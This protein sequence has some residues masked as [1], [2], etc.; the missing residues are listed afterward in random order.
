MTN[1]IHEKANS[2]VKMIL[3]SEEEKVDSTE[4]KTITSSRRKYIHRC[5]A[6]QNLIQ[7]HEFIR[8]VRA[9]RIYHADCF[10][11]SKCKRTLQDDDI[12]SL[13]PADGSPLNDADYLCQRC[14]NPGSQLKKPTAGMTNADE[15]E[16]INFSDF[17]FEKIFLLRL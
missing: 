13:M 2:I 11:C 12:A 15:G 16:T 4:R 3:S 8:R 5:F 17:L 6:C 10:V 1:A 14:S 7:S 9:G